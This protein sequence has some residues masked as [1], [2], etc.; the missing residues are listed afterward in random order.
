MSPAATHFCDTT[1]PI[2]KLHGETVYAVGCPGGETPTCLPANLAGG[3]DNLPQL[4]EPACAEGE[5][6]VDGECR[7][8]IL[9][10]S[11]GI[12]GSDG[13]V[14]HG[15]SDDQRCACT[16]GVW[17][18]IPDSNWSECFDTEC[19]DRFPGSYGLSVEIS[20]AEESFEMPVASVR[21]DGGIDLRM[22]L[23]FVWFRGWVASDRVHLRAPP[24]LEVVIH[25]GP[26]ATVWATCEGQT[27]L[28]AVRWSFVLRCELGDRAVEVTL[29]MS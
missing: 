10:V 21:S 7:C 26:D 11:G 4:C 13:Y 29:A 22:E 25:E 12:G 24:W 3:C 23:E 9:R 17:D 19:R 6:C 18:G 2:G 5:S 20:G 27:A 14:S 28:D 8:R 1:T 16:S 15:C